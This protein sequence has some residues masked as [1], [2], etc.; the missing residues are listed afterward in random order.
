MIIRIW[1]YVKS[2]DGLA[3]GKALQNNA[4]AT[5]LGCARYVIGL[6]L[7]PAELADAK[8][9]GVV[10]DY[11]TT[12][13]L[14]SQRIRAIYA[15]NL[16][17]Q[18]PAAMAAMFAVHAASAGIERLRHIVWSHGVDESVDPEM[19]A[20]HRRIIAKVLQIERCP[21]VGAD[22]G[23]TDMDHHHEA[24]V[25]VDAETGALVEF[26]QGWWKEAAQI[27]AAICEF[28][29]VI[30]SE[31]NRRY[32]A[33]ASGVYHTFSDIRV[34]DADGQIIRG[35]NGLADRS[36]ILKTHKA[37]RQ[38]KLGNEAPDAMDVGAPW[39]LARAA[40]VLAQPR[41]LNAKTWEEVHRNLARVG[42]RYV[43][44]AGGANLHAVQLEPGLE[45]FSSIAAGA[46][47]PRAA[48]GKLSERLGTFQPAP[49]DLV[50]RPF[51]MPCFNLPEDET[52]S[53]FPGREARKDFESLE[54][55]LKEANRLAQKSIHEAQAK[56][57][58]RQMIKRQARQAK[59]ERAMARTVA[60]K[61]KIKRKSKVSAGFSSPHEDDLYA[62]LFPGDF[63]RARKR[64][65]TRKDREGLSQIYQLRETAAG[66][67]YHRA[68]A[69]RHGRAA[70]DRRCRRE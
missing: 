5:A 28:R 61:I 50:V 48:M 2:A 65:K 38:F 29:S 27:A 67:E 26:G 21:T 42:F 39:N 43:K 53:D 51:V 70:L 17:T 22:H 44:V 1:D 6:Q 59:L 33:D 30:I 64:K 20:F 49:D 66:I 31:P 32:V 55:S 8:L 62:V 60:E 23:D 14:E 3:G 4:L 40:E 18:K 36:V 25:T 52:T 10:S 56:E 16:P 46:A 54:D 69:L 68:P 24:V 15:S 13:D 41:I 37:H 11:L 47:Y 45:D 58:S 9:A 19:M 7:S 12:G 34:A 57:A 63:A 35:K